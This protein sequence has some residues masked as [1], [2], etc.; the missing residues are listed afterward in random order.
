MG[1]RMIKESIRTSKSV[2]SLTDFQFRVWVYL[3]TYVDDYGRGSADPEL[4]KGLVFTRRKG[5]TEGQIEKAL[6]DLA[7]TGMISLYKVDGESF[8]CFPNWHLHQRIQTKKSKFPAPQEFT[9]NNGELQKPTVNHRESPPET[10]TETETETEEEANA[11]CAEPE[12]A[13]T[14]PVVL[15][16][17]NDGTEY[18]VTYEEYAEFVTIYQ[19]VDVLQQLKEMR[20]WLLSNPAKRKTRRGI[21]SF[22]NRWLAKEQDAGGNQ[23]QRQN[24]MDKY[25][26]ADD[27][28]ARMEAHLNESK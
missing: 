7:N 16:P 23:A 28:A 5:V 1:N 14:P 6:A 9:D 21:M 12:T 2:N 3:I 10:E 25:Q 13:S 22:I 11:S 19:A 27:W 4:L 8:F 18:P 24:Q 17:L 26:N 15:L 20:G